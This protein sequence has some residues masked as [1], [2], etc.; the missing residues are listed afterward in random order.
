MLA[1]ITLLCTSLAIWYFLD[2]MR[3]REIA[4]AVA[5]EYCRQA[6][7]QFLDGTVNLRS[8]ALRRTIDGLAFR[9]VYEFQYTQ[10]DNIRHYGVVAM[11]R[12]Q[13]ENFVLHHDQQIDQQPG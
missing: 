3:A 6:G 12:Q 9:R 4:T 8:L 10:D 1:F 5:K 13:V 11:L 2:G 7:L